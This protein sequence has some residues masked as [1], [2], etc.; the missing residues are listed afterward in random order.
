MITRVESVSTGEF[1]ITCVSD[2]IGPDGEL[3]IDGYWDGSSWMTLESHALRFT[4]ADKAEEIA[5]GLIKWCDA[6]E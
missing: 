3:E 5:E 4:D 1:I 6:Y 2:V